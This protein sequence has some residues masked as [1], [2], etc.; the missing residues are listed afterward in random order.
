MPTLFDAVQSIIPSHADATYGDVNALPP[1]R[2]RVLSAGSSGKKTE[3]DKGCLESS[4]NY[5]FATVKCNKRITATDWFQDVRH[6]EFETEDNIVC[7]QSIKI[8]DY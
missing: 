2:I 3:V 8:E 5:H 7:V 6:I 1:P 4:A